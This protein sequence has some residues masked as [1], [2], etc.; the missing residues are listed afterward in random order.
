MKPIITVIVLV[1][2]C[3]I[4]S[5]FA[6]KEPAALTSQSDIVG[7]MQV[8]VMLEKIIHSPAEPITLAL[9]LTN[10]TDKSVII[11]SVIPDIAYEID[12]QYIDD[13]RPAKKT[14]YGDYVNE[15]SRLS[16]SKPMQVPGHGHITQSI[17]INRL[18]DMTMAG[19]YKI[20]VR[21][22]LGLPGEETTRTIKT[23]ELFINVY[24]KT[25]QTYSI[26]KSPLK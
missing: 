21:R 17:I 25:G 5:V 14:Q 11:N 16:S 19:T 22:E 2:G 24:E 1:Y 20:S 26:R 4:S 23:D 9:V 12:M 15:R 6:Q 3:V 18:Y 8:I 10:T 7:G 13:T